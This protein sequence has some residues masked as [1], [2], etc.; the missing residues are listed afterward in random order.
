MTTRFIRAA[1]L[2]AAFSLTGLSNAQPLSSETPTSQ[3]RCFWVVTPD[4][5]Y[6]KCYR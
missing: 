3:M 5:A 4:G 6:I 1:L 2:L